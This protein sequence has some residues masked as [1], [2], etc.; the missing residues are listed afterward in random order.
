MTQGLA[1]GKR[2]TTKQKNQLRILFTQ[3]RRDAKDWLKL[4]PE[5]NPQALAGLLTTLTRLEKAGKPI[6]LRGN[7]HATLEDVPIPPDAPAGLER[8]PPSPALPSPS[9]TA[10]AATTRTEAPRRTLAD[11]TGFAPV[12]GAG[13]DGVTG[14]DLNANFGRWLVHRRNPPDGV[15]GE[16]QHPFTVADL[17]NKYGGGE[18]EL[19]FSA[20]GFKSATF[21]A[22]IAGPPRPITPT[23]QQPGGTPGAS[24]VLPA[25]FA[26]VA[27]GVGVKPE[28]AEDRIGRHFEAFSRIMETAE[29]RAERQAGATTHP[30][31]A[32]TQA[33]ASIAQQAIAA[34]QAAHGAK[35]PSSVEMLLKFQQE[36]QK[37]ARARFEMDQKA[38]EDRFHRDLERERTRAEGD[39]KQARERMEHEMKLEK[40]RLSR[41]DARQ[42]EFLG[43]LQKLNSRREEIERERWEKVEKDHEDTVTGTRDWLEAQKTAWEK[44]RQEEKVRDEQDRQL[45]QRHLD[46]ILELK[47][48]S[49]GDVEV[50]RMWASTITDVFSR[51]ER[52][53]EM[54]ASR[55]GAAPSMA[56]AP[57]GAAPAGS[58]GPQSEGGAV[59]MADAL[60]KSQV[61]NDMFK[62]EINRHISNNAP[63]EL[64]M[65]VIEGAIE[66]D[67]RALAFTGYL[68]ARTWDQVLAEAE[69]RVDSDTMSIWKTAYAKVWFADAQQ[70]YSMWVQENRRARMAA[71]QPPAAPRAE[72]ASAPPAPAPT[73]ASAPSA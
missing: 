41:E 10:A 60:F 66:A 34:L 25:P 12:A 5:V 67:R 50:Q 45:R 57:Q 20:D 52:K 11:V 15:L 48:M 55:G 9:T 28:D 37:A 3:G 19:T 44:Q 54:F 8:L 68:F 65:N 69:G 32:R 36:E 31:V 47:K 14:F 73:G 17:M 72:A 71:L 51:V 70:I 35:D 7:G 61:F 38:A 21:R 49:G 53:L 1:P 22:K 42:K 33:E 16:E 56:M 26:D 62:S 24:R 4:Y 29:R 13:T 30:E 2:L 39:L 59:S 63:A 58:A 18:Y 6:Q 64:F 23:W 43:E 46:E 40:E 27:R